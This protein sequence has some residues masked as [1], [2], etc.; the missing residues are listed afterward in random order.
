MHRSLIAGTRRDVISPVFCWLLRPAALLTLMLAAAV[1]YSADASSRNKLLLLSDI[2]FNPIADTSLLHD[3]WTAAP[4]QWEA[5]LQR[6]KLT[7]FSRYGQDTNWW[8]LRS[9]L[10]QMQANLPSPALIIFTGDLLA[11]SFRAKYVS[12]A[13]DNTGEHYRA[14]VLK[15][16]EFLALELR[17]RFN[18]IPILLTPGNNDDDCG[19]YAV[20]P[21]GAFLNDT[22]DLVSDL[23]KGDDE[24]R[25]DW[26]MLGSYTTPH[27]TVQKLRMISLNTVFL[28]NLY[29]PQA[30]STGCQPARSNAAADLLAWLR[31]RLD[32]ARQHNEHIWLMFHIPPGIDGYATT[33]PHGEAPQSSGAPGAESC[34]AQIV[35]MWVPEWTAQFVSLLVNY[36]DVVIAGFAGHTHMDDFRLI[37]AKAANDAFVLITPAIS[38]IYDQNPSFR[39][40]NFRSNGAVVG[41]STYYLTNLKE[42]TSTNRGRWKREYRFS[43][44]WKVPQL[45]LNSLAKIDSEV[46]NAAKARDQWVKLYMVSSTAD[47]FSPTVARGLYCAIRSLDPASYQA[48]Y[49]PA[50]VTNTA[51]PTPKF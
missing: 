36:R 9:A 37:H 8:L 31:V 4:A 46:Q 39:I 6:S 20:E 32:S 42:A 16:V 18:S 12:A 7:A 44:G 41:E 1:S 40:V 3:L 43:H 5:I 23:A 10:D 22:A 50:T 13:G 28:S 45:D 47:A 2:H 48:C 33:H 35:P 51:S 21:N 17:K 30:F 49:C 38:P 27:P 34:P 29:K 19:D 15:T 26:R 14:F 24:L 11:H 25:H